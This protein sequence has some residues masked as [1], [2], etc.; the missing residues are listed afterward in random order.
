V[1]KEAPLNLMLEDN[2]I[3]IDEEDFYHRGAI[4]DA[5]YQLEVDEDPD[6]GEINNNVDEIDA[7]PK[8]L[9][10]LMTKIH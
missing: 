5:L 9:I 8:M 1:N 2:T 7:L 4:L 10:L 3:S 6:A